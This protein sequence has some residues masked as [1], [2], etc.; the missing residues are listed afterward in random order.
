MISKTMCILFSESYTA[1]PNELA[2]ERTVLRACGLD[3]KE[4]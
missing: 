4:E 3:W 1:T 2:V